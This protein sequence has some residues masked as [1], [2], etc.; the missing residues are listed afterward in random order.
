MKLDT[1]F[2]GIKPN[3]TQRFDNFRNRLFP[4]AHHLDIKFPQ[5]V[6]L[7]RRKNNRDM[8]ELW[9]RGGR[10]AH[11][12]TSGAS[13]RSASLLSSFTFWLVLLLV[14]D[15]PSVLSHK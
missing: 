5:K 1:F 13:Q 12:P 14:P 8:L 4:K 3:P 11:T 10:R 9:C 6:L 2:S 7:S 15:S